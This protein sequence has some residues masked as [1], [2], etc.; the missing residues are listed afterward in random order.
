MR[1]GYV[2][3]ISIGIDDKGEPLPLTADM[4]D[5]F[6]LFTVEKTENGYRLAAVE[7]EE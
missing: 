7:Q 1:V 6:A 2:E 5:H 3:A 4:A